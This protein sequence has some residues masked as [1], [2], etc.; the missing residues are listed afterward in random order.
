MEAKE[1]E[2][3]S[4]ESCRVAC[5]TCSRVCLGHVRHCLELGGDHAEAAHIAML[6]T[7][8]NIC[9][10]AAELMTIDSEWHPTVCDLC[11]Q[12]CEECADAYAAMDGMEDCVAACR[13]CAQACRIMVGEMASEEQHSGEEEDQ[14]S[15]EAVS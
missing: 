10:T 5:E 15:T 12:V 9:R 8:A 14:A 11:A 6:L 4:I 7:C 3:D 2:T 13:Q 1:L